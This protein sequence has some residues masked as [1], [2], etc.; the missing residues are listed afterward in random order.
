MTQPKIDLT[1]DDAAFEGAGLLLTFM[2]SV[3]F[4]HRM[5]GPLIAFE[6]FVARRKGRG[7]SS[8]LPPFKLRQ[9]DYF[10]RIL[11]SI[12]TKLEND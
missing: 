9:T 3:I 6:Q 5:V 10:K 2:A 7:L 1:L 8:A 12:A 11:E 4:S